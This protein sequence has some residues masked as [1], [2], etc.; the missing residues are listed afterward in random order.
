VVPVDAKPT[1]N[2]RLRFRPGAQPMAINA[3]RTNPA[4]LFGVPIYRSHFASC[5]QAHA[6]RR[7]ARRGR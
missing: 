3:D 6:W 2:L 4:R 5:P 7:T 1:G